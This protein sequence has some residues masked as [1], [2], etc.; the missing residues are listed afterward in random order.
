MH[1]GMM[2]DIEN[3]MPWAC[4]SWANQA[5]DQL[6]VLLNSLTKACELPYYRPINDHPPTNPKKKK[7]RQRKIKTV[8]S[9]PNFYRPRCPFLGDTSW[10]A[11]SRCSTCCAL[12]YCR[13][14]EHEFKGTK[15]PLHS[16]MLLKLR[17]ATT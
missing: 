9:L 1:R 15:E 16:I 17:T 5:D 12:L 11:S 10:D 4:H 14:G 6:E 2:I 3:L 7:Q 8:A 13:G